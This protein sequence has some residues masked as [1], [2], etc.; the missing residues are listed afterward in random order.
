VAAL[1][2]A[3]VER[4]FGADAVLRGVDLVA[5]RGEV[6]AL[7]GE[8]G[9][10]KTTLLR[11]IAG[12]ERPDAGTVEVEGHRVVG[13]G[14]DVPTERRGIGMVFQDGAL[15]PHLDV[16][17][18]VGYG[19]P[20]GERRGPRVGEML[21]LVGLAGSERRMPDT[22]S[23]GQRQRVA[24]A[25]ALAPRPGL[26]LLDE[27]FSNL[28]ASLR[29]RLRTEVRALLVEVGITS[30]F[31]TH[32]QEEAFLLGDSLAVIRD[33]RIAQQAAPWEVYRHPV[34]PWVAG[35]V[36]DA[37]LLDGVAHGGVAETALGPVTV[38]DA[39]LE[40]QVTVLVRPEDVEV[41]AGGDGGERSAVTGR[42][43]SVDYLGPDVVMTVELRGTLVRV[44]TRD[45]VVPAGGTTSLRVTAAGGRPAHA[46]PAA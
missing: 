13:P 21:E 24:L 20:R 5:G 16:G 7:L 17:T 23:G 37:N 38:A 35:F 28:D 42:I 40:G 11:C 34:D 46:W 31:V 8:S 39:S 41:V 4:A 36:G 15:F 3:G 29:A 10:G 18:N 25:R 6:V 12:L 26:L 1:R 2:V 45:G 33:G 22:L 30:V 32:D 19:L 43:A 44:R 9:S 27:P 14:V